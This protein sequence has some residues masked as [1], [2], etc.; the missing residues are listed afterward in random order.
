VSAGAFVT[1]AGLWAPGYR[2]LA[3]WLRGAP[4]AAVTTAPAEVIPAALRRR[5]S[6]LS[7][8]VAEAARAAAAEGGVDLSRVPMV[9]GS[10]Y[11]EIAA[12]VEMIAS[13]REGEGMP[14]PTRFHNSVHNAPLA[15]VSIATGNQGLATAIAAGD[16]TAGAALLEALGLLAERGGDV[17]VVL[18]DEAVPRPLE[19]RTPWAPGAVALVLSGAP[20][21]GTRVRL[22]IPRRG[23]APAI[24]LPAGFASHPCAGGFALAAAVASR[25]SGPVRLAPGEDGWTVD[26]EVSAA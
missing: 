1:G 19:P 10:G 5:A 13:F 22:G 11:G 18:A 9:L 25:R 14:S 6:A 24:P 17:L 21:P 8:M 23:A 4:D 26:L 7:R 12:A 2:D 3:A 16:A 20:R 15:Y